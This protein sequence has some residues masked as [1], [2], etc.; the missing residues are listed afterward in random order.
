MTD[1]IET[2][3]FYI[4]QF[5]HIKKIRANVQI[6]FLGDMTTYVLQS[7]FQNVHCNLH[8]KSCVENYMIS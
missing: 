5:Q 4:I 2:H 3:G 1:F 8:R 6:T 7:T